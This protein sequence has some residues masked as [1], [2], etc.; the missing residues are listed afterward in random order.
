MSF[1][2]DAGDEALAKRQRIALQRADRAR[3][4]AAKNGVPVTGAQDVFTTVPMFRARTLWAQRCAGC[5]AADSK[6]RKGPII[7]PGHLSRAWL[8]SFVKDPSGHAF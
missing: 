2:S 3:A 6:D 7:G 4:L 5:H 8:K 1:A